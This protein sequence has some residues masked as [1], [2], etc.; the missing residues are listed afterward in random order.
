MRTKD[1]V[2]KAVSKHY[3]GKGLDG[4]DFV[5][6]LKAVYAIVQKE[7]TIVQAA[8]WIFVNE[9]IQCANDWTKDDVKRWKKAIRDDLKS[10]LLKLEIKTE[11]N[12][13][14]DLKKE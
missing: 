10:V 13:L 5:R 14:I 3:R 11:R 7:E 2:Y 8:N 4:Q 12:N 6:R 1:E 9:D